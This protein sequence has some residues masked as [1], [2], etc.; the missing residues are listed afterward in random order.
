MSCFLKL[1]GFTAAGVKFGTPVA[2]YQAKY[3][4]GHIAKDSIFAYL[5]SAGATALFDPTLISLILVGGAV[6]YYFYV[7]TRVDSKSNGFK[8]SFKDSF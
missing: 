4:A 2:L 1:I 6:A 3:L 7:Y 8:W 5:Q